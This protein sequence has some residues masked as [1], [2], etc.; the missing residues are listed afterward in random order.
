MYEKPIVKR[1]GKL[2]EITKRIVALEPIAGEWVTEMPET[3]EP[4]DSLS[5]DRPAP[6]A[7]RRPAPR[8]LESHLE[9]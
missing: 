8:T 9:S 6:E 1:F 5:L 4:R 7:A 2:R 3:G